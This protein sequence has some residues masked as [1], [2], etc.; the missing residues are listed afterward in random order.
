MTAT[1]MLWNNA[2]HHSDDA[3]GDI[4]MTE[5]DDDTTINT[6]LMFQQKSYK[7]KII[8]LLQVLPNLYRTRYRQSPMMLAILQE[9]FI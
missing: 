5:I 4:I 3:H 6:I 8:V 7:Y 1:A 2:P 9:D